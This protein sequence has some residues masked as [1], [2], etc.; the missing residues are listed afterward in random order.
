MFASFPLIIG[1]ATKISAV[2]SMVGFEAT[3]HG[4]D[5]IESVLRGFDVVVLMPTGGLGVIVFM[6]HRWKVTVLPDS[7]SGEERSLCC[8]I[9]PDCSHAR[10]TQVIVE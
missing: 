7:S 6:M 9:S 10:S 1:L 4:I 3:V 5:A 2:G 8:N